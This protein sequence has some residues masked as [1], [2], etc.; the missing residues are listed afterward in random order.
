[1]LLLCKHGLKSKNSITVPG[2]TGMDILPDTFNMYFPP[3]TL[4]CLP[5][6]KMPIQERSVLNLYRNCN[7]S[8]TLNIFSQMGKVSFT[9]R[10]S[11][12]VVSYLQY[13]M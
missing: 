8:V 2:K 4:T 12:L 1:M 10:F 7:I 11:T 9:A 13:F 6:D 3:V 5:I